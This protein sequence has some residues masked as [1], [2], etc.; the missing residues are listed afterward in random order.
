VTIFD[1]SAACFRVLPLGEFH[2]SKTSM[3]SHRWCWRSMLR[4]LL[5][6]AL[7]AAVLGCGPAHGAGDE[8]TQLYPARTVRILT[9][10][11]PGIASDVLARLVGEKL[12]QLWGRSVVVENQPGAGGTIAAE[13]VARAPADGHVLLMGSHSAL[14]LAKAL[15]NAQRYDPLRDFAPIGRVAQIPAVL[16]VSRHLPVYSVQDLIAY[17][18]ARPGGL[19]YVTHGPGTLSQ[20]SVEMFE[21]STGTTMLAVPYKGLASGLVDLIAGRIDMTMLDFASV[22]QHV[23]SGDLRLLGVAGTRRLPEMPNVPTIAEQGVAGYVVSAWYGLV[24]PSGI[25]PDVLAKLSASLDQVRRMPDV[26]RRL[27]QMQSEPVEDT[28]AQFQAFIAAETERYAEIARR[29]RNNVQ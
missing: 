11:Q 27:E 3:K 17:A 6:T 7:S 19:T 14:A 21:A 28:P 8:P 23:A 5:G 20:L 2:P 4:T 24:A 9:G 25:P 29:V 22:A 16:V 18:R 13:A 12:E 1:V 15:G 26:R 10:N